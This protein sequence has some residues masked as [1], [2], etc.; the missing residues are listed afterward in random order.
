[1]VFHEMI[2]SSLRHPFYQLTK[3]RDQ[4][5]RPMTLPPGFGI[6]FIKAEDHAS[7]NLELI[8]HSFMMILI[9]S[10]SE[11]G[12]SLKALFG[13]RSRPG[14]ESVFVSAMA[15]SNSLFVNDALYGLVTSTQS[16]ITG[17]SNSNS[18]S[19]SIRRSE[20]FTTRTMGHSVN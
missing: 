18:N 12:N 17:F 2:Q 14:S 15:E 10:L 9:C 19:N 11:G 6:N 1:M 13:I 7:G 5:D 8:K 20:L 16:S 4:G 3:K